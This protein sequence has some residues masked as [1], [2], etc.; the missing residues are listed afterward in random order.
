MSELP[1]IFGALR[2][3]RSILFGRGQ[4]HALGSAA[5][6]CG[7]R[8]LVCTDA[9]QG[10]QPEFHAMVADLR[11]HG[12]EVHVFDRTIPDL[13]I[14][15]I[16]ACVEEVRRF[17]PD[18]VIGIGGGSSM[19]MAKAVAVLLTHGGDIRSYYGE[20]A[21]P[22]SVMPLI[23]MPTTAGTGSEVTPVAVVSDEERGA[24]VGIASPY[25]IPLI[26]I[27]DPELTVSCP[28]ALTA[29]S[30]ADAL[31][32]AVEAYTTLARPADPMLTE[33]HVFVGKN[34]LSDH[35]ARLAVAKIFLFLERAYRD[36]NDIEAREGLMLAALAAGCA[37]GTAGTAAAHALQYPVGNL[38]HT[39][40]GDG[41]ATLL[42]FVMQF[43]QP[44]CIR[45]FAELARTADLPD[46]PEEEMSQAFIDAVAD[47]LGR[48]GIPRSLAALGLKADQ[49]EFVAENALNAARLVKNNPRPLDLSAMQSITRAAF[50]GE[51]AA[52]KSA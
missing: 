8:A 33:Q 27:C 4:R 35:F 31:T 20:F 42:P 44:Y 49:Q 46:A 7:R 22:G 48:V 15:S 5:G 1:P 13:P 29:C 12:L 24:K 17:A 16:T 51:R 40:H 10:A 41:V 28:P 26:A 30:G 34:V 3:P 37:F 23:A 45:S 2:L 52:L 14:A 36:G 32:H 43:N 11:A 19:D 47:L 21:V 38:T 25:L 9:R 39:A 50:S 6:K 18:L